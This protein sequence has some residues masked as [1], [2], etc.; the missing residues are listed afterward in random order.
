MRAKDFAN[1]ECKSNSEVV[2]T[3]NSPI[4]EIS[5]RAF[6]R[7]TYVDNQHTFSILFSPLYVQDSKLPSSFR[8][9]FVCFD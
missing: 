4:I 9:R 3:F 7:K 1:F 5:S 8:A 2:F 6:G